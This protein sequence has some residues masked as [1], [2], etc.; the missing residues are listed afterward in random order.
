MPKVTSDADYGSVVVQFCNTNDSEEYKRKA[1]EA[2]KTALAKMTPEQIEEVKNPKLLVMIGTR[3]E[4]RP[5]NLSPEVVQAI[6]DGASV[7]LQFGDIII[8]T[9]RVSQVEF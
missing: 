8:D 6:R 3:V 9:K 1:T 2:M 5:G 7:C 4:P